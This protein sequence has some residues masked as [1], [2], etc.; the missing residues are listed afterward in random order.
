MV[1]TFV[2]ILIDPYNHE[3]SIEE[4]ALNV[5]GPESAMPVITTETCGTTG[6]VKD[7]FNG[8]LIPPADASAI[9]AAVLRLAASSELRQLSAKQ[10]SVP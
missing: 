8:L 2:S 7:G 6:V 9:E 4:A 5:P 1:R 3:P 10:R